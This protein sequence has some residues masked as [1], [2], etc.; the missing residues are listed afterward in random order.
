MPWVSGQT[1]TGSRSEFKGC[2]EA[3]QLAH[4]CVISTASHLC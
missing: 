4:H 3:V 2:H 1:A